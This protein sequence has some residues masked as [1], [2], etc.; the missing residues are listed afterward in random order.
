MRFRRA[1]G[2]QDGGGA[3]T[4]AGKRGAVLEPGVV[5]G[6]G[7]HQVAVLEHVDHVAGHGLAKR[8]ATPAAAETAHAPG[9]GRVHV[10]GAVDHDGTAA[11]VVVEADRK[12]VV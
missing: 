7:K 3:A 5:V 4:V 11:C 12:S 10:V 9:G 8:R 2:R 6:I 1:R